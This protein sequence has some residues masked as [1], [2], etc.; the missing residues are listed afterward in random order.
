MEMRREELLRAVVV[1]HPSA[2]FRG[3][4]EASP[5]RSRSGRRRRARRRSRRPPPHPRTAPQRM[6][7]R[8]APRRRRPRS[9]T[10]RTP[11]QPRQRRVRRG[12]RC[13]GS[14]GCHIHT[15]CCACSSSVFE[16]RLRVLGP[17][18]RTGVDLASP[19]Q[20]GAWRRA[21]RRSLAAVPLALLVIVLVFFRLLSSSSFSFA[22]SPSHLH[23]PPPPPL[24]IPPVPPSLPL[25]FLPLPS[26]I[27]WTLEHFG[28]E[29]ATAQRFDGI[30][31]RVAAFLAHVREAAPPNTTSGRA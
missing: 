28:S 21:G 10:P 19:A 3:S 5:R 17:A 25:P 8:L 31:M 18:F 16:A 27:I 23:L 15:S 14:I 12:R 11:P 6:P 13:A 9:A 29:G 2:R 22:S 30:P 26:A 4:P 1:A 7:T 24:P 20:A